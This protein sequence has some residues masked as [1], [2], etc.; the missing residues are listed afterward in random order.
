MAINNQPMKQ[1]Y[2]HHNDDDGDDI[3]EIDN[4]TMIGLKKFY[5]KDTKIQICKRQK[6]QETFRYDWSIGMWYKLEREIRPVHLL[7]TERYKTLLRHFMI[8][9]HDALILFNF[10]GYYCLKNMDHWIKEQMTQVNKNNIEKEAELPFGII[11]LGFNEKTTYGQYKLI[12]KKGSPKKEIQFECSDES[13]SRKYNFYVYDAGASFEKM[14]RQSTNIQW[15]DQS[16]LVKVISPFQQLYKYYSLTDESMTCLM[17]ANFASTHP[18]AFL[19]A[20]SLPDSNIRDVSEDVR[21]SSD[22]L[23]MAVQNHGIKRTEIATKLASGFRDKINQSNY[24]MNQNRANEKEIAIAD[25]TIYNERKEIY[26]RPDMKESLEILPELTDINRGP[27]PT[28]LIN[29]LDMEHHYESDICSIMNFP[30]FFFK[31]TATQDKNRS[32]MNKD[33][34]DFAQRRLYDEVVR[35]Q[36]SFQ[37]LF[38]AVYIRT[39]GL[40]DKHLFGSVLEDNSIGVRLHFELVQPISDES[41][42]KW[43]D[44]Y[45]RGLIT[46]EEMRQIISQV[47]CVEMKKNV[48]KRKLEKDDNDLNNNNN[49]NDEKEKKKK[50]TGKD[51][52]KIEKSNRNEK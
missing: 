42:M 50:K 28:S 24:R 12:R 21:Y 35:Q 51:K 52:K 32:H 48:K 37:S 29:P 22:S 26:V 4:A 1:S 20:K 3:Y 11:M 25:A 13:L 40:L 9:A 41:M 17:D 16:N 2:H 38:I 23:S 19:I 6:I 14:N 7:N 36:C 45:D 5:D 49:N 10:V 27:P 31:P 47:S 39:F 8:D 33:Q 18:P 15:L 30:H 44:L 46:F 34:V 43:A